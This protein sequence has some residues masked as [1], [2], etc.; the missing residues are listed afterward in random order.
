M[1]SSGPGHFVDRLIG[2]CFSILAAAI[3][4]YCAVKLL[5]DILPALVVVV[6]ALTLISLVVGA[7]IVVFR[8][9]RNRW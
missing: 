2:W 4:L 8:T 7:G 1:N 5:A 3:A 9:I 6:G